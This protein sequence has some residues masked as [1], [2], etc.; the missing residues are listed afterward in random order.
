MQLEG[1]RRAM[2]RCQPGECQPR[3]PTYRPHTGRRSF[4]SWFCDTLFCAGAVSR[5]LKQHRCVQ[6]ICGRRPR[7]EDAYTAF[8][9]LL[10]VPVPADC[11][12]QVDILPPRIATQVSRA[13]APGGQGLGLLCVV[14]VR[15]PQ[16]MSSC[17]GRP[18][19][20]TLG[21]LAGKVGAARPHLTAQAQAC[22]CPLSCARAGEE[23]V[24]LA[25]QQR[26]RRQRRRG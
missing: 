1:N 25:D 12:S 15:L 3:P 4:S 24:K 9:F 10:E 8:P 19:K 11:L 23:R 26:R 21:C 13:P 6:A 14:C 16:S 5:W 20:H 7:M 17:S 22:R 18:Q 2:W